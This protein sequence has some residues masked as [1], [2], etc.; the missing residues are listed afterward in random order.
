MS[1]T[2][3]NWISYFSCKERF[4]KTVTAEIQQENSFFSTLRDFSPPWE[5]FFHLGR[6]K[7]AK[8]S[9][10]RLFQ[11]EKTTSEKTCQPCLLPHHEKMYLTKSLCQ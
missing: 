3:D 10:F 11:P 7:L 2:E 8:T 4:C 9:F 5:G 1:G 6:K